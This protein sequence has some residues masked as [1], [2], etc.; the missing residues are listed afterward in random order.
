MNVRSISSELTYT[1]QLANAAWNSAR[2]VGPG[3]PVPA[4]ALC[5]SVAIGSAIGAIAS[6]LRRRRTPASVGVS[7]MVGGA[8][9]VCVVAAW[10]TRGTVGAATRAA[11]RQ[12]NSARDLHW[13]EKHPIAYG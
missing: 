10:E 7:A 11:M 13:L 9:G 5:A 1:R 6:A 12:I 4:Q 8:V 2:S 3:R